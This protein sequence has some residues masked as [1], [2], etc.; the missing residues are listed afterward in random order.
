MSDNHRG[1]GHHT[2]G[3]H[4]VYT[5]AEFAEQFGGSPL[6]KSDGC[7]LVLDDTA[8]RVL[9]EQVRVVEHQWRNSIRQGMVRG[10]CLTGPPGTGKTTLAKLLGYEL[11]RRRLDVTDAAVATVLIDGSDIARSKYGESEQRIKELF[12]MAQEGFRAPGESC[13]LIFDDID[14]IFMSRDSNHAKEWHFSQDS[15]FFH[16]ID[17]MDTSRT[18][19]VL[20][21]NRPDLVD[22]AIRDRFL[23][24]EIGYP[25]ADLLRGAVRRMAIEQHYSERDLHDLDRSLTEAIAEGRV[26]SIRD[27]QHFTLRHYV[28][29]VLACE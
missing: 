8:A 25:S 7:R 18:T 5:A 21:T 16:A 10:F 22:A 3:S 24:Y 26:R 13:V 15:V 2:H 14:S 12:D 11:A 20:T 17:E 27:A 23:E 6:D 1:N 4:R 28:S 29:S 9:T 19:V